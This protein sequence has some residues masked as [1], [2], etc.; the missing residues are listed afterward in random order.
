MANHN[1]VDINPDTVDTQ[2]AVDWAKQ[3]CGSY[4]T[5]DVVVRNMV[6]HRF[7][8]RYSVVLY[9]FYFSSESDVT[10]FALRWL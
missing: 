5:N 4:I 2:Q 9:R 6:D 10:V 8:H 7:G 3:H 1:W